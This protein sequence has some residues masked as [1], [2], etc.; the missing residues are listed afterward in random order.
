MP[1]C[2]SLWPEVGE[3]L[4]GSSTA[5]HAEVADPCVLTW[6]CQHSFPKLLVQS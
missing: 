4:E 3:G 2:L 6:C 5:G 1:A